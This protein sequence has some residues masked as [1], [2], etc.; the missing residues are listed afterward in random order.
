[1]WAFFSKPVNKDRDL[2]FKTLL[3]NLIFNG[4]SVIKTRHLTKVPD[5]KFDI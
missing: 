4:K 3:P 1:M 2:I 5:Q